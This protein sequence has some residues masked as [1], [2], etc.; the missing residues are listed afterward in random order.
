MNF[1]NQDFS[2]YTQNYPLRKKQRILEI[3][4]RNALPK[5][6]QRLSDLNILALRSRDLVSF[7]QKSSPQKSARMTKTIKQNQKKRRI[8]KHKS[9]KKLDFEISPMK[10]KKEL[11]ELLENTKKSFPEGKNKTQEETQFLKSNK[12][13]EKEFEDFLNNDMIG[14]ERSIRKQ[15][16]EQGLR[17]LEDDQG[18]GFSLSSESEAEEMKDSNSKQEQS[19]KL[20]NSL[21]KQYQK[22]VFKDQTQ[23]KQVLSTPNKTLEN[24]EENPKVLEEE[25]SELLEEEIVD[26]LTEEIHP[27]FVQNDIWK[28]HQ[29]KTFSE[30]TINTQKTQV[31][32]PKQNK[33]QL[34]KKR[35]KHR[36]KRRQRMKK[37]FQEPENWPIMSAP[38]LKI[39]N[40]LK[41]VKLGNQPSRKRKYRQ[42]K[43]CFIQ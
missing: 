26:I 13:I 2:F 3:A 38:K 4:L 19:L 12:V 39:E 1:Q 18:I 33:E 27:D 34:R 32:P 10:T 30:I 23:E 20:I 35:R 37:K 31:N 15:N 7:Y 21:L 14:G 8:N 9:R 29:E 42:T 36:R 6:P 40:F 43:N 24:M 28:N 41:Q 5:S 22:E 16:E 11:S 17:F 25:N